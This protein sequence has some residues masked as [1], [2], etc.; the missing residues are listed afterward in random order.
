MNSK[1]GLIISRE[2]LERVSKKSFIITTLLVPLIMI[3]LMALP[4][5][6]MIFHES[7]TYNYAVI[8]NSGV[9]A[10]SLQDSKTLTFTNVDI[11]LDSAKVNTDFDG[12]L[13][14]GSDIIKNPSNVALYNH[15]ASSLEVEENITSQIKEA[16]ENERLKAYN[17]DNLSQILDEV[18]ANVQIATY[19]ISAD[20]GEDEAS[21][22]S[23]TNFMF[24]LSMAFILYMFLV[25]YGQMVMTS[26]IEEKNNRVLEIVV[27]SIKPEQLMMGKILGIGLVAL[28]QIAIWGV[29]IM[30]AVGAIIPALLPTDIM[31][32]VAA[33]NAGQAISANND[34]E[35]IQAI[36]AFT[37][38]GQI[39]MILTYMVLFLIG[40][41]LLYAS[42][43]AAI[44]SAVDNIQDASQLQSIALM[45]IIIGFVCATV[46]GAEPNSTLAVILSMIPF[47]SPMLMM[48]RIPY[49]IP[50]W[51]PIVSVI[52]LYLSFW[53]MVWIAAKIYR[54]GIFMYGKKPTFKEL[55][56]WARYK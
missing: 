30:I 16:I 43:Y 37:N 28:T 31:I 38:V 54:V 4:T 39:S 6:L 35:T 14:I 22:S 32:D 52:L 10:P 25:I 9:I 44:G 8:D 53:V 46:V 40:G 34:I 3:A 21:T 33:V 19:R 17:I 50:A 29:L 55:I 2:Y 27:S 45:P 1:I 24:G 5:V 48:V 13:V 51:E 36:A 56:R 41:F 23:L 11:P 18:N 49:G 26:I 7:D 47:T 42:I 15:D 20:T 12:I